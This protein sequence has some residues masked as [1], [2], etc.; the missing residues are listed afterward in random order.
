MMATGDIKISLSEDALWLISTKVYRC[1]AFGCRHHKANAQSEAVADCML[2]QVDI[3]KEG[4]CQSFEPLADE[5][6]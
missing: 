2:K 6:E 4:Q 3:G 5:E 1:W